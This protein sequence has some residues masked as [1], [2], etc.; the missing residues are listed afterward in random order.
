M[1]EML[2]SLLQD[3]SNVTLD[4]LKQFEFKNT[5]PIGR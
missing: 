3:K 4:M 2:N 5:E 1:S